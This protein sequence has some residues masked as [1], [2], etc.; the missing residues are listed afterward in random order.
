MGTVLGKLAKSFE[1]N[2]VSVLFLFSCLFQQW[3]C[4]VQDPASIS[5]TR[6]MLL[7]IKTSSKIIW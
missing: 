4:F 1:H 7:V 3:L 2:N 6:V 5:H